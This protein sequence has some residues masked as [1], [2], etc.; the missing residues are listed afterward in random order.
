MKRYVR[1]KDGAFENYFVSLPFSNEYKSYG[2]KATKEELLADGYY[3][4][5]PSKVSINKLKYRLT[6]LNIEKV[7]EDKCKIVPEFT[8]LS[9]DDEIAT[10]GKPV[11]K[12]IALKYRIAQLNEV[13]DNIYKEYLKKYSSVER[14]SFETKAN[15]AWL[16]LND[17]NIPLNKTP[18]L[19]G[20]ANGDIGVR[21][22][23]AELVKTK[24]E[25][26]KQIEKT[27]YIKRDALKDMSLEELKEIDITKEWVG[28]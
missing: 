22:K 5:I 15:E 26:V 20:L 6:K 28:V 18:Y 1:F 27:A 25:Y 23:L 13:I 8:E 4:L 16:V 10:F 11:D 9:L 7:G 14:D 24:I 12:E 19:N 2:E 3:E 17:P 21:N